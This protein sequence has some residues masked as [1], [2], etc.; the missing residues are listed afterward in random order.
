MGGIWAPRVWGPPICCVL[1][2]VAAAA[3]ALYSRAFADDRPDSGSA[4]AADS[5]AESKISYTPVL[6]IEGGD[7]S[8]KDALESASLLFT[9]VKEPLD[10]VGVLFA[11]AKA[12]R[13]RMV[14]AL[15]A[16]GYFGARAQIT[17]A[18]RE[19]DDVAAEDA[20][21]ANPPESI[22]VDITVRT[23]RQFTF[24]LIKLAPAPAASAEALAELPANSTGLTQGL[25]ARSADVVAADARI[26]SAL[27]EAGYPFATIASR[28]AI[29]DHATS[30]L[31]I[32]FYV[33][34]GPLATFGKVDVRGQRDMDPEFIAMLAPFAEGDPFKASTLTKYKAELDRLL[35]FETVT[36][37]EAK[38]LDAQGRLP[39]TVVVHERLAHVVGLSA[40]LSTLE[41]TTLGGYWTHR[42]LW[43]QA[44]Q[45]RLEA[46]SSRLFLN[47]VSDYEYAL[48][49]TLTKPAFPEKRDDLIL[50]IG[51]KRERPDAF[52]RDAVFADAKVR[53]R[54]DATLTGEAGVTVVEGH[55]KDFLG[56]RD[57]FAI[58]L[59]TSL[60]SDTR[61][62]IL[63]ATRGV[64][65]S[66]SVQPIV[67]L[68]RG[69]ATSLRSDV[70]VST[71]YALTDD[72]STVIA[73][74][75]AAGLSV[76]GHL[77]DLPVD[78]R[79]FAGGGGSVRGYEYQALSPRDAAGHL[80]GGLSKVEGSLE[81]RSW[82][83][84]DIGLAA[85]VDAG[86]ASPTNLPNF[87][88]VRVGVGAGAR[89]KTPIG[90]VRLDV[91]F[92]IDPPPGGPKF[93][94]YVALGQAF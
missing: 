80:I 30:K 94:L 1:L 71:Y 87:D 74:R 72:G 75:A 62:N 33:A 93:G 70:A 23:G 67:S 22:A 54:F 40:S 7:D 37:E 78:M 64:R 85:F 49:A 36:I 10:S 28:E 17:I 12:D 51:A 65:A 25:P 46:Q 66:V 3:P 50:Q 91:A 53:R 38:S 57:R 69:R 4:R 19:I 81:L 86:S 21:S 41:G 20:L 84:G 5:A 90:P 88:D 77:T 35:V 16:L 18:G 89:Y 31:E 24:G 34:P 73:G 83:A 29:A 47:G 76:A 6:K 14:R 61:D 32:T 79:F 63:D 82:V 42:N 92:P 58:I 44:E 56:E 59:P 15:S 43:G 9:Y 55:E 11:R 48:T 60:T 39:V 52:E 26:V 27:R 68:D 13:Q 2:A 8:I 45:L